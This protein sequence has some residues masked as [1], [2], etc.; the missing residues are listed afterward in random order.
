MAVGNGEWEIGIW[1]EDDTYIGI[2]RKE[3][4]P[5][6]WIQDQ[7]RKIDSIDGKFR[8]T[9]EY[10]IAQVA[11]ILTEANMNSMGFAI[12]A[13]DGEDLSSDFRR[14]TTDNSFLL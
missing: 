5:D 4:R 1:H 11:K 6:G 8:A 13:P 9:M 7:E 14:R 2:D 12:Q 3:K 10:F